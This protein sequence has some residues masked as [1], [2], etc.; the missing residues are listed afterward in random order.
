MRRLR[1][2]I[3]QRKPFESL[4]Q[5]VFLEVLRTGNAMVDDLVELLRPH[6]L[7]QPQYNVLRIL[8]GAEPGG[9]PTGEV[10]ERMVVSREPDVT[11]LLVRMEEHGLVARERRA[12]NRRFVNVRITRDGLRVLKALD[13]PVSLMHRR[14]LEHMTR[15]ELESLAGLLE[16]A[17]REA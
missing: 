14:Q 15:R 7:T 6:G 8:R 13:A 10:G 1:R 9:L 17:R 12:D 3:K 5:E 2:A 11:R 4:Q 16:R